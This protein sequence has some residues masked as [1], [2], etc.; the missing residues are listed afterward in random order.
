MSIKRFI[1]KLF[2]KN[3]SKD[4]ILK[5]KDELMIRNFASRR[6]KENTNLFSDEEL[7][8]IKNNKTLIEKVYILGFLDNI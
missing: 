3:K 7:L 8:I 2:T 6:I 4:I 5:K 1:K